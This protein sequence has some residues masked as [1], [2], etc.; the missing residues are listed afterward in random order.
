MHDESIYGHVTVR[1]ALSDPRTDRTS[2]RNDSL[3][4]LNRTNSFGEVPKNV[5]GNIDPTN[6][7]SIATAGKKEFCDSCV[8][9]GGVTCMERLKYIMR[10]YRLSEH[11]ARESLMPVCGIDYSTEPYVLLHAGPHKTGG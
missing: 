10:R 6:D 8:H 3:E 2:A 4:A 5:S 9:D 11:D 7:L 1:P